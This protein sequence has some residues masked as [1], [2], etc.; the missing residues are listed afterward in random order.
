VGDLGSGNID[1]LAVHPGL[2]DGIEELW[3]DDL[4]VGALLCDVGIL[5]GASLADDQVGDLHGQIVEGLGAEGVRDLVDLVPPVGG[6]RGAANDGA[7]ERPQA[8]G[9]LEGWL[10][11]GHACH[12]GIT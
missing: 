11:V 10:L 6:Q 2:A 3:E 4:D 9:Q 7:L 8:L 1:L 12:Q 5:W